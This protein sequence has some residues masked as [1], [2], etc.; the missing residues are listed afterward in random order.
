MNAILADWLQCVPRRLRLSLLCLG[1]AISLCTDGAEAPPT[2]LLPKGDASYRNELQHS[3]DRGLAWLQSKQNTNGWWSSPDHPAM[4]AFALIA[5]Q[6]DS[7]GKYHQPSPAFMKQGYDYLLSCV[8][9]DGGIHRTNLVTYNTAISM[10]GLLA[11]GNPDYDPI[12]VRAR[13]FL[14]G[15]QGDFGEKGKMDTPFDGGVGYGSKYEHSDMGNT[16]QAL[17]AIHY[18]KHLVKD[19]NPSDAK[20]LNLAAA[21]HFLQSCQNLPGYNREA[22]A[23]DDPTNKGG[24]IYYPGHSMAGGVTNSATGRVALRSYG[25]ISYGGMLS[26]AYAEL[27]RQ[28]PRVTAVMDWLR[29][30]FTLDENP[31]MEAQGL[32]YYYHT[33]AKAL[34]VYGVGELE[35]A[36]GQKVDWRKMLSQKL[37][38]LQREDGSWVNAN[39]RWWENDPVLVTCYAVMS[40]E[41]IQRGM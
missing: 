20:N 12:I 8:K 30:N 16:L 35:L 27:D 37:L 38:N 10:M 5:F 40:M 11:A 32:Y 36:T 24:F 29:K 7:S 39:A 21:I 6:G 1:L 13:K 22:W 34:T 4:S 17:E 25:S 14:V 28:D 23:S 9:T 31:G 33:M 3:I 41:M 15:L 26:Y 2:V 18:S 19:Q